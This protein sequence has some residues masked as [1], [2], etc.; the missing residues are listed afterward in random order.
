MWIRLAKC[1]QAGVHAVVAYNGQD[2]KGEKQSQKKE[3][4]SVIKW[5]QK[6]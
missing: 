4:A 1:L 3:T 2:G 6:V 5:L